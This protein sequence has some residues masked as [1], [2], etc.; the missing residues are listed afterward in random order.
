MPR[1]LTLPAPVVERLNDAKIDTRTLIGVQRADTV[2][3]RTR[4]VEVR[5]NDDGTFGIHGFATVYDHTY[6]VAGGAPYG[7]SE[8]IARG[9]CAK[10][11]KE[12]ADVRLLFDHEGI[13]L[14]RTKSGTLS[15][16]DT[17]DG[18]YFRADDLDLEGSP[19]ARSI[20]SAIQRG[21]ID[22]CSFAFRVT[23][24]DWS[25]DYT[26]RTI[27]E[28]ELFDVSVVTYPANPA[29]IVA[30]RDEAP[31]K[32]GMDLAYAKALATTRAR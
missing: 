32:R 5:A 29:A 11:V 31:T 1:D 23:R 24:Q 3:M 18:L 16:E 13:P 4:T 6:D 26:D 7:W 30:E 27:R 22:E 15:L 21:D 8:T 12:K 28:V 2:E 14:A 20:A 19:Y 9:A 10:S 25:D 17:A